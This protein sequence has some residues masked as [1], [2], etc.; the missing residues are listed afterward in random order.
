L[1]T[2]EFSPQNRRKRANRSRPKPMARLDQESL[3]ALFVLSPPSKP[4]A[5]NVLD[6]AEKFLTDRLTKG[7]QKK[8]IQ[9]LE[10]DDWGVRITLPSAAIYSGESDK[11]REDAMPF[12]SKL[13][14]LVA[15]TKRS[16]LIEGH[17]SAKQAGAYKSPWELSAMRSLNLLR[18]LQKKTG[19]ASDQLASASL[20]DSRPLYQTTDP[21]RNSRVEVVLLNP[22]F[23]F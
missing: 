7:E 6:E 16:V 9:D 18:F 8:Y 20:G 14:T 15:Q 3:G 13:A 10:S 5:A 1:P 4:E 21:Q 12:I 19:M 2:T 23:D 11:F 22:D 17:V